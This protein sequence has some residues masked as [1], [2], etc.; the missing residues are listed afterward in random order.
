MKEGKWEPLSVEYFHTASLV[1]L[2]LVVLYAGAGGLV[3]LMFHCFL[4]ST[5]FSLWLLLLPMPHS[6][7]LFC[8]LMAEMFSR[9]LHPQKKELRNYVKNKMLNLWSPRSAKAGGYF[10]DR[11]A[12]NQQRQRRK[13]GH[14]PGFPRVLDSEGC[15][16]LKQNWGQ[17]SSSRA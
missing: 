3:T 9:F 16:L 8:F 13:K 12:W 6:R 1:I 5:N 7:C 15:D 4:T 14:K 17:T 10:V 11:Q 2:Y